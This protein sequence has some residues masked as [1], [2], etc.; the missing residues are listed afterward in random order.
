M[1]HARKK[2][3]LELRELTKGSW[4]LDQDI[5]FTDR[6]KAL[7]GRDPLV[8]DLLDKLASY[9]PRKDKPSKKEIDELKQDIEKKWNVGVVITGAA[10]PH[11]YGLD[12][13]KESNFPLAPVKIRF[14]DKEETMEPLLIFNRTQGY[15]VESLPL[16]PFKYFTPIEPSGG[17]INVEINLNLIDQ[18]DAKAVKDAVWEIVKKQLK[19]RKKEIPREPKELKFLYHCH[20]D[21]FDNYVRWYDLHIQEKLGF[22]SIAAWDNTQKTNPKRAEQVLEQLIHHKAQCHGHIPGEDKIEKGV[23]KIYRAINRKNYSRKAIE[24]LF[25]KYNCPHHPRGNCSP[26]CTYYQDWFDRFNRLN[27]T[28]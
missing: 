2:K 19:G 6:K 8:K 13:T 18:N 7:M 20:Q 4:V 11:I 3:K 23:K 14:P 17:A 10:Q 24:P 27:P 16:Y 5:V 1:S 25:E 15:I 21:K 12:I 22:R 28:Q 26:S 9:N